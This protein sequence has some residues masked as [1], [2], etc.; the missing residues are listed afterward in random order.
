MRVPASCRMLASAPINDRRFS[1]TSATSHFP[2]K[3]A[4]SV[5]PSFPFTFGNSCQYGAPIVGKEFAPSDEPPG[6]VSVLR[7]QG[8]FPS[9]FATSSA[10]VTGFHL[11]TRS[12]SA[13]QAQLNTVLALV[14]DRPDFQFAGADAPACQV[15]AFGEWL[16]RVRIRPLSSW[17]RRTRSWLVRFPCRKCR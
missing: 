2:W 11:A 17:L 1:A 10:K 5:N 14:A 16:I 13:K 15:V 12:F 3:V 7:S 9:A 8:T 4:L 6:E